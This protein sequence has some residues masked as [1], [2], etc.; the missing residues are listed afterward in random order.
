M[1]TDARRYVRRVSPNEKLYLAMDVLRPG[2]CIQLV[3]EGD[4]AVSP[5]A[6]E[7]AVKRAAQANRGARLVLR[8]ALGWARWEAE[9]P[10]P[11][12]RALGDWG[13]AAQPP[14]EVE[15][16]LPPRS[17]PTCEIVVS[18]G[19]PTRILFR[20]FHGVMDAGGLLCFAEDVFRCLR[21]EEPI[22]ADCTL[23]DAQVVDSLVGKRTRPAMKS[24]RPAI[25]GSRAA[26]EKGVGFQL[27]KLERP[28]PALVARIAVALTEYATRF[29]VA[30][31]RVMIP[32]DLRNY[33]RDVRSTGNMTY[34]LFIDVPAQQRWTDLQKQILKHLAAKEPL[35]FD[36][37]EKFL[38]WLPLWLLKR[39]YALWTGRH[40][41]TGLYPFTALV[42]HMNVPTL[43]AFEGAGYKARALYF[44]P[45]QSDS[46]PLA[47][48]SVSSMN[49]A[50][51]MVSAPRALVSD[52]QLCELSAALR[53]SLSS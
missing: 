7:T 41:S 33:K 6:L 31:T 18:N 4:G 49:S 43:H 46:I 47:I 15:R 8:G 14:A 2:F 23:N 13:G 50:H 21:G 52:S 32:V 30:P 29:D 11:P 51:I 19:S 45:N 38:S 16:P 35:Y 12:V 1:T 10:V 26:K 17:G 24:D 27:V 9:G 48:S 39:I 40:R 20:C 25:T 34:P 5:A 37:A 36:P 28:V 3:L 53:D 22:G 42:T 44:L